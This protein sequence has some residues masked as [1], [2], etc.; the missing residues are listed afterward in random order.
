MTVKDIWKNSVNS[1]FTYILFILILAALFVLPVSPSIIIILS[2]ITALIY[3]K[4][5]GENNA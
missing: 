2:G 1:I 3:F 5:K 4:V